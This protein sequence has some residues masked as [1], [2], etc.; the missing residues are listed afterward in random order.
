MCSER[1]EG[2][3]CDRGV[4][5]VALPS[6]SGAR[7]PAAAPTLREAFTEPTRRHPLASP[8]HRRRDGGGQCHVSLA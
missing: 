3:E 6:Q 4:D 7:S 1:A 8:S 2:W 5:G